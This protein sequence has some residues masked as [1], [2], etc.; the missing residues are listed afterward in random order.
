MNAFASTSTA[1]YIMT[2]IP[3]SASRAGSRERLQYDHRGR[4]QPYVESTTQKRERVAFLK[5]REQERRVS[6][7]LDESQ[8]ESLRRMSK[9][10]ARGTSMDS[11][12]FPGHPGVIEEEEEPESP[13]S[14]VIYSTPMMVP[15]SPSEE[16]HWHSHL[17]MAR[18]KSSSSSKRSRRSSSGSSL[19]SISEEDEVSYGI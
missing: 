18:P 17:N 12:T 14:I 16:G 7:W 19:S 3:S 15:K 1:P 11:V 5:E 9:R 13:T 6:E 4:L 10:P 2:T 8:S